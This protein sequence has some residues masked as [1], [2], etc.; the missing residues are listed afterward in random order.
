MARPYQNNFLPRTDL[1]LIDVA[2]FCLGKKNFIYIYIYFFFWPT[3]VPESLWK[4]KA[5]CLESQD[6]QVVNIS[7]ISDFLSV[8]V[9]KNNWLLSSHTDKECPPKK[10]EQRRMV[11]IQVTRVSSCDETA[12]ESS[13]GTRGKVSISW[14]GWPSHQETIKGASSTGVRLIPAIL[15]VFTLFFPFSL[16]VKW[17]FYKN[18]KDE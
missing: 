14:P 2:H 5:Q 7:L 6:F 17:V 12:K 3:K 15:M 16:R 4:Q 9:V 13:Q 11:S 8:A 1:A 10:R 18:T